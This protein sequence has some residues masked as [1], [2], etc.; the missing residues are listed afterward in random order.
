[1]S[2]FHKLSIISYNTQ[3]A[4]DVKLPYL[5]QLFTSADFL[6]VQEHGLF[7]T[8][9]DWFNKLQDG[10][11]K[12]GVSAMREEDFL[13]GRPFGGCAILWNRNSK[14]NIEPVE[15]D[16]VRIAAVH[17]TLD[18]GKLLLLCCVY[19]PCDDRCLNRNLE[20]YKMVLNDIDSLLQG[21]PTDYV[22]ICGDFNTDV[23]RG[24]HQT[25]TLVQFLGQNSFYLCQNDLCCNFDYTFCSKGNGTR[26]FIDHCLLSDNLVETLHSF[27]CLDGVHNFSDHVAIKAVLNI[28]LEENGQEAEVQA[29]Q[30][31]SKWKFAS[32]KDIEL[33]QQKLEESLSKIQIPVQAIQC[34]DRF[35]TSR[36]CLNQINVFHD[37]MLNTLIGSADA[38]VSKNRPRNKKVVPGWNDNVECHFRSALFW[39]KMWVENGRPSQGTLFDLRKKTRT[40]YHKALKLVLKQSM[41]VRCDKMA[42]ALQ[43]KNNKTFWKEVKKTCKQSSKGSYP[44]KMDGVQGA[45][46]IAEL[47]ATKFGGIYQ[48][49]GYDEV[50]MDRL[51]S[52]MK[53][54]TQQKCECG[55]CSQDE[56]VFNTDEVYRAIMKLNKSKSDGVTGIMS[57]H[58]IHGK[59]LISGYL[60]M[61][62][63]AMLWHGMSPDGMLKSTMIP[64][65][66]GRWKNLSNSGNFRAITLGSIVGKILEYVVMKREEYNLQT[67]DLQFGFKEGLSTTLCTAMVKETISYFNHDGSNVYGLLLD[68]SKA[69][70]RVNYVKLFDIML[71]KGVCPMICRLLL[72]M[73]KNQKLRLKWR[74][75]Y[76][77]YFAVQ[78]GVKQGGVI[79]PCLFCLYL[80]GLLQELCEKGIGCYMG[81]AYAGAFSYADDLTLLS[82]SVS[83]LRDMV[84]TCEDYAYK[85]DI[86]FNP[87][88]SQL[89]IFSCNGKSVS[90]PK[91]KINGQN[92]EV[93]SKVSH[94]GH[95]ISNN[96]Y[97]F[98]VS[99]VV[100]NFNRQC[101]M[102]LHNFK[103]AKSRIRNVLF[104][105]YCSSFYGSQLLPLFD[106][107]IESLYRQWRV[108]IRRVW[109]IPWHTH[110][111]YL[112]H[113]AGVID[114]YLW[115]AKRCLSFVKKAECSKNNTVVHITG[116]ARNGAHSVLG[117]NIRLLNEKY[118]SDFNAIRKQ[119]EVQCV[120]NN[121]A[122]RVVEQ[123]RELIDSRDNYL[124]KTFLSR[125]ECN[126][127]ISVLCT[128]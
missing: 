61:L 94:L 26:S 12:H 87:A 33:Y 28:K 97:D 42:N 79:S 40:D 116:I 20:I 21:V 58:F 15:L 71:N 8:Q 96:I 74:N 83:A 124:S 7:R 49:V 38:M 86:Q 56:H 67:S 17:I 64:I 43:E 115:F 106:K 47:F 98:D 101:N 84:Q 70:D 93:F 114:P 39:H 85:F 112:P 22:C 14:L 92:V 18:D 3:C 127:I 36:T 57:D 128:A 6:L 68:A 29:N 46:N 65:P 105:K 5:E 62:F 81:S 44:N 119:W 2:M 30:C 13:K 76:T 120:E 104:H 77:D 63:T 24:S 126:E 69:F 99:K 34:R 121:E 125:E 123:I 107:C 37:D 16:S 78:N 19:M 118:F 32:G 113:L 23:S 25:E 11:G 90:H 88:K 1:M 73:Y 103:Y 51:F 102:F 60:A 52:H 55:F 80:D 41:S 89:I 95:E 53:L 59:K 50:D 66:K 117:G 54:T 48:S 45:E 122:I 31:N 9:F 111:R 27:E 72:N 100:G 108:A 82:P 91:I 4:N 109:K 10:I 35:C 110:C 75:V